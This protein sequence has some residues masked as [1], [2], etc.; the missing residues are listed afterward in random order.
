MNYWLLKW[1]VLQVCKLQSVERAAWVIRDRHNAHNAQN[2]PKKFGTKK[3]RDMHVFFYIMLNKK[4]SNQFFHLHGL[5][6]LQKKLPSS[7]S[8]SD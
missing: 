6:L 2:P 5:P 8:F 4:K 1:S 7:C 3:R